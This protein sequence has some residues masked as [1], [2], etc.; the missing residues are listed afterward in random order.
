M[1]Q[2]TILLTQTGSMRIYGQLRP[3][4]D[5]FEIIEPQDYEEEPSIFAEFLVV[6]QNL[7]FMM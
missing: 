3:E 4:I 2:R 6:L 1:F 5:D 7:P